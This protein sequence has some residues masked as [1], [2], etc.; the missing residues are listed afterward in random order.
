L[1]LSGKLEGI[2]WFTFETLK[3]ITTQHP[4]HTFL[5]YFD[6]PFSKEF[7]FSENIQPYILFPQARHPFLWYWWFEKTVNEHL[8]K[9]KADLFLS[10][11]G[12]LPLS[13][14]V[15]SIPVIHDINFMHNANGMPF[16]YKKYYQYYFP[17][18]AQKAM[19]IATVSEYSKKDISK[20]FSVDEEKIDVVYNGVNIQYNPVSGQ[21]AEAT[22]AKYA[23]GKP[24]FLF[25]GAFNQRKNICNMFLAFDL[26]KKKNNSEHKFILVGE[27]MWWTN[28]MEK[29][30]NNL[31]YKNDIIFTGRL[32]ETELKYLIPSA[33]AMLYVS[34]FE[35]FGIPVLEA[36]QC[37]VPVIASEVTSIPE[38]SGEAA[39]YVNP[40][41]TESISDAMTT[42][43]K[44]PSLR[45]SLIEKGQIQRRKFSWDI[46]SKKLWEC[47]KKAQNE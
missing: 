7:I 17:K 19:R 27:K 23:Q 32:N 30:Y 24:Y 5:F 6:R 11:D 16:L 41:S 21:Q 14:Q 31:I 47:I 35:G 8:K 44:N 43:Y 34:F 37:D 15:P 28:E 46:T 13:T 39:L 10:P 20:T 26:F 29:T 22:R 1:L 9:H 18:F 45:Q 2:G 33:F 38:V 4:E 12:Y 25:I 36:M 3:R 40:H 42:L